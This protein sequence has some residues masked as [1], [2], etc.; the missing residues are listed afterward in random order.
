[1]SGSLNKEKEGSIYYYAKGGKFFLLFCQTNPAPVIY[2]PEAGFLK[3][4]TL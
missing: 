4:C 2:R 3:R 1:M